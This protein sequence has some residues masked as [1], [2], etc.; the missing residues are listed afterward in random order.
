MTALA[1]AI[2]VAMVLYLIDK[3]QKW[4]TFWKIIG[5]SAVL[6]AVAMGMMLLYEHLESK[7]AE[8]YQRECAK[9]VRTQFPNAYNDLSDSQLV[10]KVEAKFPNCEL[11]KSSIG[12]ESAAKQDES[13][14]IIAPDGTVR[15]IP[16][17]LVREALNHGGKI[18][19]DA[20]AKKYGA[21]DQGTREH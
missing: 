12:L 6:A 8:Q 5:S 7:R 19:Y 15:L 16:R 4:M 9:K 14:P 1:V 20:L 18:D 11:P 13:I 10:L 2:V 21:V 3:N 17:D